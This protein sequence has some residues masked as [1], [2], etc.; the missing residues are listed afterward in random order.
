MAR[1][2]RILNKLLFPGLAVV[3][4][5]IP[6]AAAL[7]IYTFCFGSETS[8]AAYISYVFSAYATTILCAFVIKHGRSFKERLNAAIHG[9]PFAHRYLTDVSFKMHISLNISLGLNL[10]YAVMKLFYGIG[11][12]SV[13]FI[14]LAVYYGMLALMRFLLLRHANRN[15]FGQDLV[16]EL[17][18]Y[19]LCGVILMLMN[20]ALSGVVI[21]VVSQN[22]GFEY[23]GYLI[24]VMAMY[25]FYNITTAVID[26]IKYRKYK[27]PVMSAAKAIKLA[28]ALVSMLSL[29]TA[30]LAQFGAE[31]DPAFRQ[32]MT[33][34]TGGC[35]CLIVLGMAL[36][37][38]F[39]STKEIKRCQI[40]TQTF[41]ETEA[42]Q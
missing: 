35:V 21:L 7:L 42:L 11:Y 23:A 27:S 2:K 19:R 4:V 14:T 36:S 32:I 3:L 13:W 26:V 9:N 16:S 33:G 37:M 39:F 40:Q 24:Y 17:R 10:L 6:I 29:E 20:I 28:A 22:Q 25:A 15:T 5:C 34:A 12:R 18:Q 1:F 31:E 38:I 30:M 41:Q 8:P